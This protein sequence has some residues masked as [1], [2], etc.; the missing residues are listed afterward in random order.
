MAFYSISLNKGY[1]HLL[2]KI[3]INVLA[4]FDCSEIAPDC[5]YRKEIQR[6]WALVTKGLSPFVHHAGRY[7]P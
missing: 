2:T 1:P 3:A 5:N 4:N 7:L 6:K